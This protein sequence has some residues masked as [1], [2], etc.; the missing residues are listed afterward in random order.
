M[1]QLRFAL[2][3]LS[4]IALC[5]TVAF[6]A[7]WS[8]CNGTPVGIKSAP[9]NMSWDQCSIPV[10]TLQERAL[11]S[12]LY[13]HRFYSTALG[14]GSG[15]RQMN[16]SDCYITHGDGRSDVALVKRADIDGKL[17]L[18]ITQDD[19]CTFSWEDQHITEADVMVAGDLAFD[20]PDE[21]GEL[22]KAPAGAKLGALVML[23]ELGHALGLGHSTDF[24]I[25]R[26]GM[27]AR[28]PFVGMLPT[29]GGLNTELTGDDVFGISNIYGYDPSYRN[30]FVSSQLL[31]KGALVDNNIDPTRGDATHPDPLLVCP[32]D[33]VN[34]YATI[35]NDS[36]IRESLQIAI[37]ADA[38]PNAYFFPPSPLALFNLSMTRGVSSFPVRF[39]IPSSMPANVTQNVFVSL[40]TTN[41]WDRKAYD[42]SARS[43]LR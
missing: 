16:G 38:N 37:Y 21:S 5:V 14:F 31:L 3:A 24:S 19:G 30:V 43:R 28:V 9:M 33:Q 20:R 17:G 18:T 42:N 27:N 1:V 12:A 32:G 6:P 4:L 13:E 22:T 36:S 7:V 15:F 40:P 26:N 11:F 25:M 2:V 23:H 39:T 8:T 35:G 29:S 41:R 10:D 34:F